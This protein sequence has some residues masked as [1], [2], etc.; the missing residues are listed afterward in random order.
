MDGWMDGWG[1]PAGAQ[2]L[3]EDAWPAQTG[4]LPAGGTRWDK[5]PRG[6]LHRAQ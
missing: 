5:V 2:A 4:L 6:S 3:G 1:A